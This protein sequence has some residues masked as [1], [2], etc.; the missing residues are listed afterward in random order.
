MNDDI[1]KS[2]TSLAREIFGPLGGIVEI[3]AVA[4]SDN[5]LPL[6]RVSVGNF[7]NRNENDL[8]RILHI[9]RTVG[10][11]HE[12]TMTLVDELG[13]HTD[14]EVTA[15]SLL[16]WSGGIETLRTLRRLTLCVECWARAATC[17][18]FGSYMH[19]SAQPLPVN[20][21]RHWPPN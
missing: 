15:P 21:L 14:H 12:S 4:N 16:L 1:E 13:W 10:S 17:N 11:F 8:N 7:A 9:T 6:N 5:K 18:W 20:S 3:G 2:E 19:W